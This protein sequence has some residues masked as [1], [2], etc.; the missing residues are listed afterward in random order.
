[1]S[2]MTTDVDGEKFTYTTYRTQPEYPEGMQTLYKY[3]AESFIYPAEAIENGVKGRL[4][5]QF[6]VDYKGKITKTKVIESLGFGC[7]AEG[8]RIV[9]DMRKWNPGLE[10]GIPVSVLYNLPIS[11][12]LSRSP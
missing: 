7:D 1:I 9:N 11:L 8:L 4:V 6:V 5:I 12:N 2:G 3:I 10:R